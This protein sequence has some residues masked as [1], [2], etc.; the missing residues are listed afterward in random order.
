MSE[1]TLTVLGVYRPAISQE[2]WQDQWDVTADDAETR[3]HFARLVL[4]E[5]VVDGLN[6]PMDFCKFG[7]MQAEFPDDPRRM[8]VGY[9]EGL[10]SADGEMLIVRGGRDCV[11]G[12]GR[13]G[14]Q[15]TC[16]CTTRSGRC[17]GRAARWCVRR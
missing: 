1:L 12:R 10:L 16:T 11:Q 6:G 5:G 17:G 13:C 15:C 7:Q 8:Q 3:D 9:D 2:T 4:I 14:L